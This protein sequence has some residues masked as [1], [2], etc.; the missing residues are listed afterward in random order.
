MPQI[1]GNAFVKYLGGYVEYSMALVVSSVVDEDVGST[2]RICKRRN[3][4]PQSIDVPNIRFCSGLGL[5]LC[6]CRPFGGD[7]KLGGRQL[8]VRSPFQVFRH[9]DRHPGLR[10]I[11]GSRHGGESRP[12]SFGGR[13]IRLRRPGGRYGS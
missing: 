6:L 13:L 4:H 8:R 9:A 5:L 12:I 2:E 7:R 1:D 11:S 3:A 10:D